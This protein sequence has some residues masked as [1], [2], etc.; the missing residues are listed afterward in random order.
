M[1]VIGKLLKKR[2]AGEENMA[3]NRPNLATDNTFEVTSS[4]FGHE[5][6]LERIH[7]GERCG[8]EDSSPTLSWSGL[9]EQTAQIL[10]V[11]EDPDAPMG[12]PFV[13]CAA[14]IEPTRT[15]LP[16]N[17][18]SADN[19]ASGVTVLRSTWGRGYLGPAPIRGH[20]RHRYVF[21]LF[22]LA[23]PIASVGGKAAAQAK[24]R[25]VFGAAKA[26]ARGRIDG[27]YERK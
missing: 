7:A 19:P 8:G 20:G 5:T 26:I 18:L 12:S 6:T 25:D 22:A 27:F 16:R 10:L 9:P 15:E 11:V 23:E 2:R 21:Q 13:H 4:D 1:A 14:L 24:P 17:G 3:W